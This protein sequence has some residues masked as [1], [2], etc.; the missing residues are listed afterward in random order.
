[1]EKSVVRKQL[2]S[3]LTAAKSR[4]AI[5]NEASGSSLPTSVSSHITGFPPF[6]CMQDCIINVMKE[7]AENSNFFESSVMS[8]SVLDTFMLKAFQHQ[9]WR[10]PVCRVHVEGNCI[11]SWLMCKAIKYKLR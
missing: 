1:M 9:G 7:N 10:Q 4:W 2:F 8:V 3:T 5:L 11:R 6:I